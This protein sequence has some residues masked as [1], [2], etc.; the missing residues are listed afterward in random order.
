MGH[1]VF[2]IPRIEHFHLH[3]RLLRKLSD[4]EHRVTVLTTDPVAFEFFCAQGMRVVDIR[5]QWASS[6][7]TLASQAPLDEF[8]RIDCMLRG[9]SMP[10]RHQLRPRAS[11]WPGCCP[12]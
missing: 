5:P 3:S 7:E 11:P 12:A 9:Q 4:R 10:T 8:A 6:S 1:V 2:G